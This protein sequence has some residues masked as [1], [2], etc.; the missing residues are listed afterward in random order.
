MSTSRI[1]GEVSAP[2]HWGRG[3]RRHTSTSRS[4]SRSYSHS[5]GH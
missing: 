3:H 1:I 2:Q 5:C 4:Y